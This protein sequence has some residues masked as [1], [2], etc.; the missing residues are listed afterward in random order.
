MTSKTE[1]A[2]FRRLNDY[3]RK[4][5]GGE[6]FHADILYP[7]FPDKMI[8]L[9]NGRVMFAELKRPGGSLRPGQLYWRKRLQ[10]LGFEAEIFYDYQ[11]LIEWIEREEKTD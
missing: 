5:R 8:L 3:V 10:T 2:T 1:A 7:G 6:I 4:Q 9:P 11:T